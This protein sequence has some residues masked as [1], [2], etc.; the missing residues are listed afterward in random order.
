MIDLDVVGLGAWSACFSGWPEF[1]RGVVAGEWSDSAKL[2]PDAIPPRERRRAPQ[3]VKMAV[4]VMSQACDMAGTGRASPAVVFSSAMGD[5]EIM[6]AMCST[7]ARDPAMVSPTKFHNSV[8]NAPIGYWSIATESHA[9]ANAVAGH[10]HSAGLGLLEAAVQ[11]AE[12]EQPVLFVCQE[13]LAHGPLAAIRAVQQPL[14]LALLLCPSGTAHNPFARIRLEVA[15]G[16]EASSNADK[17][18]P[19]DFS[20]NPAAALLPLFFALAGVEPGGAHRLALNGSSSLEIRIMT[21]G[22]TE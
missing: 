21:E 17:R 2:S 13:A 8:H 15:Q 3:S 16:G 9:P 22:T 12:E 14:A 18:L 5:M 1:R 11:C 10:D 4:E 6:D 7:L 19:L 20:D